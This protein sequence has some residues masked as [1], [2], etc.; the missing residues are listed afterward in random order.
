MTRLDK[1]AA[2]SKDWEVVEQLTN[3]SDIVGKKYVTN[4]RLISFR[5]KLPD[6]PHKKMSDADKIRMGQILKEGRE[7]KKAERNEQ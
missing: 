4:K 3:E 2:N 5:G 6:G 1:L 7:R